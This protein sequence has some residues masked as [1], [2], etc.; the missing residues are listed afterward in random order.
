MASDD[1]TIVVNGVE[2]S[3][4]KDTEVTLYCEGFPNEFDIRSSA[5]EPLTGAAQAAKAGDP[6]T[7]MLGS[8]QV[9]TGYIDRDV[10]TAQGDEHSI[11]L[12]GRGKTQDLVDCSAEWPGGQLINGDALSIATKLA[13]PYGI[14]VALGEG[15]SAGDKVPQWALNYGETGA[16]VIQRLA[17]NAGLLAYEDANGKLILGK[18][19]TARAASGVQ[20]GQNVQ[21]YSVENSMDGRYSDYVCCWWSIAAFGDLSGS[22]FF[23]TESDPNVPR[24]RQ[25]DIVLEIVAQDAKQFTINMAKWEAARRAGQSAMVRATIDSWRDSAGQLWTPNTIVPTDLPGNRAGSDLILSAV[26]FRKNGETGTTADLVLKPPTA[27]TIEPIQL[28]PVATAE[29]TPV[30]Q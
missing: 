17:R 9:I 18:A 14:A 24:H 1:L 25:L 16:A 4:W 12:V 20:Y 6:C 26:T 27:L 19:G 8:D 7:V 30:N 11:T 22:D 28:N 2:L 10:I 15:A 29:F 13:Q 23:D 21:A 5:S 3:A